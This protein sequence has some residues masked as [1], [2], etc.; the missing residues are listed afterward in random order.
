[1]R[2]TLFRLCLAITCSAAIS[3]SPAFAQEFR[4]S[5]E[6]KV[7]DESGATLPGVSITATHSATGVRAA[8]VTNAE[9]RYLVPLLSPGLYRVTFELQGFRR[10]ER[11]MV[12]VRVDER[13][14][15]DATLLIGSIAETVTVMAETP[16]LQSSTG[17][18]GQVIDQQRIELMPLSD[19]NPLILARLA[20]G[21]VPFG[22]QRFFRPFDNG[23]IDEFSAAGAPTTMNAYTIDGA[24]NQAHGQGGAETRAAFIPPA[25]AVQ[26]F[27]VETA[28][29]DAQQGRT[30]GATINVAMKSGTNTYKGESYV[31]LRDERM[32]EN[33]YFLKR[34]GQPEPALDYSRYGVTLGGP[35]RRNRT[36]FFGASEWLYDKFPDASQRSVP[37]LKQ[38]NGDFSEL[39]TQGIVIYDPATAF[40]NAAGR[41]ERLPFPGNII[42]SERISPIAREYM[43]YYPLPNQPGNAQGRLNYISG[44]TRDDDFYSYSL[45]IDHQFS[46]SHKTF[47]RYS[48]NNRIEARGHW[49]GEVNGVRPVG[50]YL[51]RIND[52]VGLDYVWTIS[53]SSVFNA[54][55]SWGRFQEDD[56][57]QSQNTFEPAS[58]G[59]SPHTA[60]LFRGYRYLPQIDLDSNGFDEIGASW[61]GGIT[62]NGWAFQPTW[63]KLTGAHSLRAGYDLRV[64]REDELF[65]GHPAGLYQF[66]GTYTRQAENSSNQFG[67]D[68]ASLM[69]GLPTGGRIE[70]FS[71]RF[72]QVFY[73]GFFV[74]DDWKVTPRLTLNLG[75]RYEYEGA[76]TER[77]NRNVRG[78]DPDAVLT[79][80][81]L[82]EAA[83]AANPIPE[84]APNQFRVRGGAR[85][86]DT[87]HRGFWNAD[88]DNV[89]PRV[90]FAYEWTDKSVV[91]GGW[92]VYTQPSYVQGARQLGFSSSTPLTASLDGGRTFRATW[93]DPFPD[94][95]INPIG[96]ALGA[97]TNLGQ[98]LSR[99]YDDI[100]FVNAQIM[101]WVIGLQHEL[102]GRFVADASYVGSR[103][104]DLRTDI[105]LNA[106]PTQYLSRSATRDQATI[107]YLN[108]SSSALP[109]PFRGLLPGTGLNG[110]TSRQ[111]LL[112]PY[113]QFT[114][115]EGRRHDGSSRYHSLQLRLDRRLHKG[116]SFLTTYTYSRA[117]E[118]L[119]LLNEA[120]ME[121]E[122]RPQR[123]DVPHRIVL[124][125]L[126]QLPLGRGRAMGSRLNRAIDGLVGGWNLSV[127]WQWQS[128]EPLTLANRYYSG[129]IR[130]LETHISQDMNVD[131]PVFDTSGFYFHDE[132]VQTDGVDD[133]AKQ[134]TDTRKN[135]D[136]NYRTLP[137]KVRSLRGTPV[138]SLDLS[139]VKSF[140][141]ARRMRAQI[142]VELY[143]ATNYVWFRA[144][145]VD[146]GNAD[147]GR[148]TSQGNLPRE[149]QLGAKLT[150]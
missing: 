114:G 34:R 69:L 28:T 21:I 33:D 107:D 100:N 57:R 22:D 64:N 85:F 89:Q 66:R 46:P 52:A 29:F 126:W 87:D 95:L 129:D 32:A 56:D 37:S 130:R 98:T 9:G 82:A 140:Q 136:R 77:L 15:V 108:T 143:N 147:F 131:N 23:A 125:P 65:D 101:R 67:Q 79:I 123:A 72:N 73:H 145:N 63:T 105:Q 133:P 42:P 43:K 104:Y 48:R 80:S 124:N 93:F 25:T 58:L 38:R 141:L 132:I 59:F 128:G 7:L 18:A 2:I 144:P 90:G 70:Q 13:V 115:I 3:S 91:R 97:D 45:R 27:K 142:H 40:T 122:E 30:A 76:P 51:R 47:A 31:Y 127:I 8:A 94:G 35:V 39:L 61:T 44:V 17:S 102:P 54:R 12:E 4:G 135:L 138:N 71:D 20:P 84:I 112:R 53:S 49:A 36:F 111:Q 110:N 1:M 134:R 26:E 81:G 68:L 109:N 149:F 118:R 116:L 60:S 113:P 83:Y 92:A 10:V 41:V 139:L 62:S 119:T 19:G 148:V 16:L 117:I 120:D 88:R 14:A 137:S 146:P 86:V 121:Y 99:F 11:E 6:G 74:Q 96:Q 75:L 78:F 106:L 50:F 24:P 103:G 5:I 55:A 150:F